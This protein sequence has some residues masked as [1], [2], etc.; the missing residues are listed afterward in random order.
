[1]NF[2]AAQ[3]S[4]GQK[5][6]GTAWRVATSTLSVRARGGTNSQSS[7]SD[8]LIFMGKDALGSCR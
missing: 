5:Y 6:D 8:M 1:M 2:P 3:Q 7:S 4:N